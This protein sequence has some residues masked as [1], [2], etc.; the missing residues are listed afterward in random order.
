[1]NRVFV[2]FMLVI[3][4]MAFI[5]CSQE[6]PTAP[7]SI[8][9][10]GTSLSK[11][12]SEAA[13]AIAVMLEDIN[14]QLSAD[15]A[16]YRAAKAEVLTSSDGDEA[17]FTVIAKDVGNKQLGEDFV[18]FDPRRPWSG[19]VEGN[20]DDITYAVDQTGD[21]VPP[22]GGLSGGQTDA[23]IERAMATWDGINCSNL[24][25]ERNPDF[26]IDIG[27]VASLNSLGGSPF[28]FADVQHAGWGDIDFV[29]PVIG[30]TF[31]F[32]FID[33]QGNLTDI[34]NDGKL[35][36]AFSEIYYDPS[37]IWSDDGVSNIDVETVALHEA[38]HGLSQEHFGT[39]KDKN[40]S[41]KASPRA[42]MN[43]I[44]DG[45]LR[46]LLGTDDGGHCSIWANWPNN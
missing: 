11:R 15:G 26:G 30:A 32:V 1:M 7:E 6:E 2:V 37:W 17:G 45:V 23:A 39:V 35:D 9:G 4:L 44:Y 12:G 13:E 5:S 29:D 19:P 40:G 41:L 43:A 28:V 33:G 3:A 27:V 25:L 46:D 18:P 14:A 38:G 22:A 16:D 42:V 34:N 10:G 8:Q 31:T 36:A 21:A 20:N 24:D